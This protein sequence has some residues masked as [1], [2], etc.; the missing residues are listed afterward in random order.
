MSSSVLNKVAIKLRLCLRVPNS[1][2]LCPSR[3]HNFG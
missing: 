2:A 3:A 1:A